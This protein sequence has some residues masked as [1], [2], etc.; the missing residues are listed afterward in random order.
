MTL[1]EELLYYIWKHLYF[2]LLSLSTTDAEPL[3]I[4][5]PGIRNQNAGPDF[6]QA[7]IRIAETI[8][9]GQVEMHINASD[10]EIH[11]HT[12][13]PAFNNVILHVVWKADKEVYNQAGVK[14]PCLELINRVD[15]AMINQY[16]Y[17]LQNE[18]WIPCAHFFHSV[19]ELIVESWAH[20]LIAERFEM[21]TSAIKQALDQQ[22][23]DW[24]EV[25]FQ[26]LARALGSSINGEAMEILA[27]V[28]PLH[29]LNKHK[30]RLIQL[31]ALLFGQA[32]LLDDINETDY[33]NQLR[34]EYLF[35]KIKYQ[36]QPMN[37]VQWKFLRLRPANF[38]TVRIAQ[39]AK[40]I[41]HTDHLFSKF[42]ASRS[43]KEIINALD[44]TLGGYWA[45]HYSF[46]SESRI[47]FK[48]L[49]K[50]T[51]QHIIINT[52][53]PILFY[54]GTCQDDE[55]KKEKAIQYLQDLPAEK[56]QIT[57]GWL[58]LG[59]VA[60][61]ALHSQ[62]QIQLKTQYCEPKKC[63]QCSIGHQILKSAK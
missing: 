56:N 41:Y 37:P 28:T 3:A 53:A 43:V 5:Y 50:S 30:T 33:P 52:I 23:Q 19:D 34:K 61:H 25:C 59:W 20:R 55:D 21:K 7:K 49:G 13:D 35:L 57:Q 26:K 18:K 16:N 48:K 63:L 15:P 62:A 58:D 10:W 31:E 42:I 45:N 22:R 1:H 29:L 12:R 9:I 46:K 54:Y 11:H 40:I 27:I 17:L 39:L 14:I 2:R 8:W 24:E 4:L 51:I 6:L 60:R 44:I 38:P 36:L 32:G 47:Q